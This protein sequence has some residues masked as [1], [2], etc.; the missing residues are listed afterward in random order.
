VREPRPAVGAAEVLLGQRLDVGRHQIGLEWRRRD[1][2]AGDL[3]QQ[4]RRREVALHAGDLAGIREHRIGDLIA[5]ARVALVRGGDAERP[6][7]ALHLDH[8]RDLLAD[9]ADARHAV[10]LCDAGGG[11]DEEAEPPRLGAKVPLA[12][13]AREQVGDAARMLHSPFRK[14]CSCGTKTSLRR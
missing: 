7:R 11:S 1:G 12:V 13:D 5:A 8:V 2:A 9:V 4:P 10:E 14:T 6:D 3:E